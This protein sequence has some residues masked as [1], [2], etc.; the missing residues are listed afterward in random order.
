M[1][2]KILSI[3]IGI[4]SF[5][6]IIL[7][8]L[9]INFTPTTVGY[10]I[11]IYNMYPW[12]FWVF[13]ITPFMLMF[14]L[15]TLAAFHRDKF[16]YNLLFPVILAA[17]ITNVLLFSLGFLR[18]YWL[19]GFADPLTHVGYIKDIL[20]YH[21]ITY[22]NFYPIS[23][24]LPAELIE[25]TSYY[26]I[27]NIMVF[28]A[29]ISR[30]FYVLGMYLILKALRY[31]KIESIFGT[32]ISLIPIFGIQQTVLNPSTDSF[33]FIPIIL[34]ILINSK[35]NKSSIF[36]ILLI[37]CLL[38]LPF[39]HPEACLFLLIIMLG[40]LI[41]SEMSLKF[42]NIDQSNFSLTEFR[43]MYN[44]F[45]FLTIGF[46]AWFSS[47]YAFSQTVKKVI[48]SLILNLGESQVE[49]YSS[50]FSMTNL[51]LND[52]MLLL[53]KIYGPTLILVTIALIPTLIVFK[54]FLFKEKIDSRYFL[55]TTIYVFI[56]LG[57][58]VFLV[59][60]LSITTRPFKYLILISTL[61]TTIFLF[62][63]I[64]KIQLKTNKFNVT[65][66]FLAI[67]IST[68]FTA[69]IAVFNTYDSPIV[70]KYN[71]QTTLKDYN[72]M[73][74]LIDFRDENLTIMDLNS[75]WQWRFSDLVNGVNKDRKNI[76]YTGYMP[77][78]HFGY[79]SDKKLGSY[80]RKDQYLIL[81]ELSEIFYPKIF[82]EYKNLW[83]FT[84]EDFKNM[85]ND[86]TINK[87]YDNDGIK[88]FTIQG[89]KI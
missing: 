87:I 2:P 32:S 59:K 21:N 28:V 85:N 36:S 22:E 69:G 26:N 24:L 58:V 74:F 77:I 78:D 27:N 8:I 3:L 47:S 15:T 76:R 65:A 13:I 6:S 43:K 44:P 67:L 82:P 33:F 1:N 88:L 29:I 72:G 34:Y 39:F 79:D 57:V 83:R 53:I 31:G 54:K 9:I 42:K 86:E 73:K 66:L 4:F 64:K 70:K 40:V 63:L 7:A 14:F 23:H 35:F 71:Q 55:L 48:N 37:I 84:E 17:T 5:V 52:F 38:F 56:V 61:I 89:L 11:S 16:E 18:N 25:I 60:D 81:N 51:G 46:I 50:Y 12:Y 49:I 80:Y 75:Q 68:T 30:I 45:L 10:E 62:D 19:V 20:V 41:A